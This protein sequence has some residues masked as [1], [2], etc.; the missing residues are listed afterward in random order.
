[1]K[2]VVL[3][4]DSVGTDV[5]Y[6]ALREFGELELYNS[7]PNELIAERI[8]DADIVLANKC[9]LDENSLKDARK[10][11]FIAEAAT[12]YNNIDVLY[13]RKNNIG[14]SNVSGYSTEA[15]AQHTMALVLT[16]NNK[17]SYYSDF[18]NSKEY[19]RQRSF[20]N[21]SNVF[22]DLI[23]RTY[24]II[25]MGNI[26]R[27]VASLAEA[28]GMKVIYFSASGVK[29]D[30]PYEM[31]D[32]DSFLRNA[33]IVSIHAPLN[34]K[35]KGLINKEAFK[36]MKESAILIN[37]GRGPIVVEEDLVEALNNGEIA[38]A[39]IDVYEKEPLPETSKLLLIEDKDK[40]LLTPH[41]AW[42]SY[43]ARAR[44]I[45]EIVLNIRAYLNGEERNRIV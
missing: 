18:V 24:G 6:E 35:T 23:G 10:V 32:F 39:G 30:L 26:G 22:H 1:M 3:E 14:L 21:I 38:A 41:Q 44:L 7:T 9:I 36:K 34:E 13:C 5:S 42:G 19:S 2:I 15:V 33:D 27:R 25:G 40:L 8:K 45:E 16:L 12:G 17:L 43:E 28:F 11:R 20:C 31:M 37:V 4:A 29:Q